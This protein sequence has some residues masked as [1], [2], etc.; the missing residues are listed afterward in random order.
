M[1]HFKLEL[2]RPVCD[3]LHLASENRDYPHTHAEERGRERQSEKPSDEG[4]AASSVS[5]NCVDRDQH[6]PPEPE[7]NEAKLS[8]AIH[9]LLLR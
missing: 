7:E 6:G 8:H 5:S 1:L 9:G 3:D 2:K 4:P